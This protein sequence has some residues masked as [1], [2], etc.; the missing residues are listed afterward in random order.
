MDKPKLPNPS[1]AEYDDKSGFELA[2]LLNFPINSLIAVRFLSSGRTS[3]ST[4]WVRGIL[5]LGRVREPYISARRR[6]AVAAKRPA[7]AHIDLFIAFP[8]RP[9][10]SRARFFR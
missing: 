8:Y 9:E 1:M 3:S 7:R 2:R 10:A 5:K 4:T 6:T